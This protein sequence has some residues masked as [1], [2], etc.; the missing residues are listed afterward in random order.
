MFNR[1]H[2]GTAN[3]AT[4]LTVND[5][6]DFHELIG[7][8]NKQARFAYLRNVWVNELRGDDRLDILTPDDPRLHAGITSFRIKGRTSVEDNKAIVAQLAEEHGIFTVHR[9]GVAKGAC[10][11]VTPSLYNTPDDSLKLVKALRA[12]MDAG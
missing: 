10:V 11:R 12:M 3:F 5:A 2:T 1:V 7:P 8:E 6:L 9:P 4:Y